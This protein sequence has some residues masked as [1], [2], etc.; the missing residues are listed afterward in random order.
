MAH[1]IRWTMKGRYTKCCSC[2]L[3]CPC[4]FW[5]RPTHTSCEGML[6][7]Q[8]DEGFYGDTPL[9]GLRFAAAYHWPGPLHEGNG[10]VQ[11]Y[12][13]ERATSAQREALLMIL[14]GQAGGP[15]FELVASLIKTVHEPMFVPIEFELDVKKRKG[16]IVIPG[17]LETVIEPIRNIATGGEHR[18]QTVLPE[19][20]EYRLAEVATTT[21]N[22]GLAKIKYN[23][24]NGHSSVAFV[25]H[26]ESGLLA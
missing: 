21:T 5:G 2:D 15:W 16:R 4:D 24:P 8:I 19:G 10:M 6:G 7:M 11:P 22:R 23:H 20:M 12:V 17:V 26:T 14:S 25:E 1:K 3:G 13:D 18:I 9:S